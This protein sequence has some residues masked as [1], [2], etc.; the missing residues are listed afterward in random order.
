MVSISRRC[1]I[2][3]GLAACVLASLIGAPGAAPDEVAGVRA[4]TQGD[5]RVFELFPAT[6]DKA[7]P[8]MLDKHSLS[9]DKKTHAFALRDRPGW[10]DNTPVTPADCAGSVCRSP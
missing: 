8:R 2:G 9:D 4:L 1:V 6:D 10:Q 7:Q 3:S 5:L